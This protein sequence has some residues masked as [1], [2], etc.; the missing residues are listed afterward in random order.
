M[1]RDVS[2]DLELAKSITQLRGLNREELL[3]LMHQI[4]LMKDDKRLVEVTKEGDVHVE[5]TRIDM[6][7]HRDVSLKELNL[8][9]RK[10]EL[11]GVNGK[12]TM[13]I[14]KPIVS[15]EDGWV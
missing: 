15:E 5:S 14:N 13:S 3:Q 7:T 11:T 6:L 2:L 1:C 12:L 9:K 10:S 8:L 4:D